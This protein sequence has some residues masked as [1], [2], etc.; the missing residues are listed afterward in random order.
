MK[1]A[2]LVACAG[3]AAWAV[4]GT[5]HAR[6]AARGRALY[7]ARCSGC[8]SIAADRV[9]PRHAGLFGRRAGSVEGYEYSPALAASKVVWNAA[10]LER[11]L[12]DPEALIPGQRMNYRLA[13]ARDRA[14]VIAYLQKAK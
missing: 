4:F 8:H 1:A 14:D 5:A 12:A 11:W 7:E 6:D 3:V 13:E 9:G 10:T 2:W